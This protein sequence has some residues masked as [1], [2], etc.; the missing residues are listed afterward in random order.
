MECGSC[1]ALSGKLVLTEAPR[2]DLDDYWCA[3]HCYPV[4]VSGWL[5]LVLRRH[6]RALH[7][8]SASEAVA[9]GHWLP[10]LTNALHEATGCELE[11]VMQFAEGDG[12]HH[13]HF[14]LVARAHDWPVE[15]KG[16]RVFAAWGVTDPVSAEEATRVIEAVG[17]QLG[18][19]PTAGNP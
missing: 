6:A 19:L 7:E 3:E 14:H 12:F 4:A 15:F 5:V 2:L 16:P 13:V 1:Q 9:L 17:S 11:Y 8:L 18:V 10:A